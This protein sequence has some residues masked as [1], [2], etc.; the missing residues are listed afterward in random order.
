MTREKV[1]LERRAK[2]M[3]LTGLQAS[4]ADY[5][6][7]LVWLLDDC[8]VERFNAELRKEATKLEAQAAKLR[9]AADGVSD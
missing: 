6:K 5:L 1:Y 4:E 2:F 9:A 7:R 3:K 8:E